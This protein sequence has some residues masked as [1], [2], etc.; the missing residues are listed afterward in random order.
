MNS[1]IEQWEKDGHIWAREAD[2]ATVKECQTADWLFPQV[3]ERLEE[4]NELDRIGNPRLIWDYCLGQ[5]GEDPVSE[6]VEELI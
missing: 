5:F 4:L 1:Y 3:L 6:I 2:F